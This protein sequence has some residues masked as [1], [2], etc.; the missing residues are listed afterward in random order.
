MINATDRRS[1]VDHVNDE[2]DVYR[3][4]RTYIMGF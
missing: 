4:R 1:P 3:V 2:M